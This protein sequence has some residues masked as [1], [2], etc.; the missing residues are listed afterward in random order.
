MFL[1]LYLAN[2]QNVLSNRIIKKVEIQMSQIDAF[3]EVTLY[4]KCKQM[5]KYF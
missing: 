2:A 5:F 1:E 3:Y 4:V